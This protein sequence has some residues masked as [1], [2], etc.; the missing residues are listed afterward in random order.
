MAA[1]LEESVHDAFMGARVSLKGSTYLAA[2]AS[3]FLPLFLRICC[4]DYFS[5]GG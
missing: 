4:T 2:A 3:F 5:L 1:C